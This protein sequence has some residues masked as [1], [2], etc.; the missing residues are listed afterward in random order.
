[1]KTR[2]LKKLINGMVIASLLFSVTGCATTSKQ[3]DDSKKKQT[4]HEV[5][6]PLEEE[7]TFTL[8]IN[9]VDD[10]KFYE[11]L[12]NNILWKQLKEKTNVNFEV[13][14]L[15]SGSETFNL[16]VADEAY[17]DILWGGP[18]LES[19]EASKYIDAGRLVSLSE[20]VEDEKLMPNLNAYLAEKP[21]AKKLI[22]AADGDIYTLPASN[23]VD[24]NSLESPIWIN[25]GW[26]DKLGLAV[27]TTLDEFVNVLRAFRDKDPNGNG[28][29]DEI[30]YLASTGADN[31]FTHTE[32]L[33]G[34]FGIATKSATL[35]DFVTVKDGKVQYAPIMEGYK[36]CMKFLNQ[37]YEEKLLYQNCVDA[38]VSNL[39]SIM[40]Q[41]TCVV[42]CMTLKE[43]IETAY[44]D[45]YV[46]I[47]PPKVEGYETNWYLHPAYLGSHG[48]FY[49]TDKCENVDILM[50]W[51]DQLYELETAISYSMGTPG[52]GRVTYENG[53]Y[54]TLQLEESTKS[55]LNDTNPTL[56][57]ILGGSG[58]YGISSSAYANGTLIGSK[59][60]Q[61][62]A[63]NLDIYKDAVTEEIWTRPYYA[64]ED[65]YNADIYKV[66]ITNVAHAYR[67][68]FITGK[69]DIDAEWDAYVKKIENLGIKEYLAIMQ[70]G[71]DG[72]AK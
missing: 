18:I 15:Q 32:A 52:E 38:T 7:V 9:G 19:T 68:Y 14:Y 40:S 27:P 33:L 36:D 31:G 26:L 2:I 44:A 67:G 17:G 60:Q 41:D 50:A 51:M 47:A 64:G 37:L 43:P 22:T 21:T 28:K 24:G 30:P 20:Y 54:T 69:K 72:V 56:Y 70:R 57:D 6:F 8:M 59:S 5:V 63:S 13:M 58:P 25:K 4:N 39:N 3:K 42:G 16:L 48:T 49:V 65:A 34:M 10:G 66:D 12:E 55:K 71:Y 61:V 29:K 11:K 53:V 1:M 35:D 46:C 62:Y 23:G 45:D